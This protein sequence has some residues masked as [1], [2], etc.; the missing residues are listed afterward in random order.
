MEKCMYE[1]RQQ[2]FIDAQL[3]FQSEA[4]TKLAT[5]EA[6]MQERKERTSDTDKALW[7][8][9]KELRGDIKDLRVDVKALYWRMGAVAGT[10]S[11]IISAALTLA[12]KVL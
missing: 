11:L 5:I 3:A 6:L 1:C 2:D 8:A 9:I 10:V 12:G 7:E 4:L